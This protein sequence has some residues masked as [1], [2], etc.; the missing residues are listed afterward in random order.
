MKLK[1]RPWIGSC[2]FIQL[3]YREHSASI[4]ISSTI[5]KI[6]QNIFLSLIIYTSLQ[7]SLSLIRDPLIQVWWLP[8]SV[9]SIRFNLT[10]AEVQINQNLKFV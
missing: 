6:I 2:L 1:K 10:G 8:C 3:F 7:N 5:V 4:P 9:Y